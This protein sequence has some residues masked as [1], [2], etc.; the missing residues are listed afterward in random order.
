ML[1]TAG[2]GWAWGTKKM[3]FIR[4]TSRRWEAV[5]DPVEQDA[6]LP[7][8]ARLV[9]GGKGDPQAGC[10]FCHRREPDGRD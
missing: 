4:A 8:L 3:E 2:V 1:K 10:V 9:K 6:E 5:A 7:D